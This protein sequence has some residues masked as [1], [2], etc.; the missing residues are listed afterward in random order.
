MKRKAEGDRRRE[1]WREGGREGGR[2]FFFAQVSPSRYG[3]R[4]LISAIDICHRV[5][6]LSP[7]SYLETRGVAAFFFYFATERRWAEGGGS[8]G[9]G[10]RCAQVGWGGGVRKHRGPINIQVLH[11]H[12]IS[13]GPWRLWR[14]FSRFS[15]FKAGL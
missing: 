13:A 5:Y 1:G 6:C 2:V 11:T 3:T 15:F 7:I 9:G 4:V 8:G 14:L 12:G 10:W